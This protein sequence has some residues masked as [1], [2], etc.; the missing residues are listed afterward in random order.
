MHHATAA[1]LD[2][3][4]KCVNDMVKL[5]RETGSLVPKRQGNPGIDKLQHCATTGW[6]RPG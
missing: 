6:M 4:I 1:R 2:V 5:K 3:S